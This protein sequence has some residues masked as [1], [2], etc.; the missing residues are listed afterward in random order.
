MALRFLQEN[1]GKVENKGIELTIMHTK[2]LS[3][4]LSYNVGGNLTY[5][6][7]KIVE[8]PVAANVPAAFN[9]IGRPIGAYYGYKAI[10]IIKDAATMAAYGKTTAFPI[11]LGDIMYDDVNKDGMIN[12]ADRQYL[13][14]G[15]LPELVYG[16]SGG[17]NFK[18]F[19]LSIL[20]QGA[21]RVHQ[22]LAQNAGFAFFNGG[23]VTSEWLDRWTPDNPNGKYPRL[24]TNATATTNNYQIPNG[25]A[26]W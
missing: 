15:S 3:A 12:D 6:R 7:N 16:I 13:G 5:S 26:S 11:A 21:T 8:A 17:L 19:E 25:P 2:R 14:G 24:S 10:G 20:F 22:Q 1:V 4:N 9:I 23:R 18:G